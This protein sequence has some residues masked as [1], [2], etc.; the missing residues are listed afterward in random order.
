MALVAKY[1]MRLVAG[2]GGGAAAVP[3]LF[4]HR[5]SAVRPYHPSV[6]EVKV[7]IPEFL[8]AVGKGVEA[9]IA[10]LEAEIGD[11]QKLLVTRTLRLKKLGIPCKHRKLILEYTHKYRLGLWRPRA[12]SPK[13]SA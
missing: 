1:W 9:H 12:G 10:K 4:L 2:G 7:G 6:Y 5:L 13:Q 8:N 3:P 11:F